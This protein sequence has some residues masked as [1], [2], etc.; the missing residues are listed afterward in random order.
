M[1]QTESPACQEGLG[2]LCWAQALRSPAPFP[3][4]PCGACGLPVYR[5]IFIPWCCESLQLAACGAQPDNEGG[6]GQGLPRVGEVRGQELKKSMARAAQNSVMT[7]GKGVALGPQAIPCHS[8][9]GATLPPHPSASADGPPCLS[10]DQGQLPAA[11]F[12]ELP[13][14]EGCP[15]AAQRVS[16][17]SHTCCPAV[18]LLQECPRK[19]WRTQLVTVKPAVSAPA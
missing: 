9:A 10:L 7:P 15:G 13:L 17:C 12:R 4:M 11:A 18:C 3:S 2:L 1:W 16:R 5:Q 14:I 6:M 8:W 19:G